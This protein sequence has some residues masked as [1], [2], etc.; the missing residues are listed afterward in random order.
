[1]ECSAYGQGQ[2]TSFGFLHFFAGLVDTFDGAADYQ[3]AR[4]VVVGSDNDF[5][6]DAGSNVFD[7]LVVEFKDGCH[8]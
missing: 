7:S 8:G 1:M 3:L 4:A 5:A 6:C 2:C